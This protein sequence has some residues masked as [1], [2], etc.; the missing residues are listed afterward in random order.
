MPSAMLSLSMTGMVTVS[1]ARTTA[2]SSSTT[3]TL[4]SLAGNCETDTSPVVDLTPSL[5]VYFTVPVAGGRSAAGSRAS[6]RTQ[7]PW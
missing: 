5:I 7:R 6:I 1:W 2:S 4:R 3:G